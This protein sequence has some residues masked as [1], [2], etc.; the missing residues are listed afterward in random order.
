MAQEEVIIKFNEVSFSYGRHI[1]VLNEVSFSVREN[2]KITLMGQNGAGKSTI[3]GLITKTLE[4]DSGA[5]NIANDITIATAKQVIPISHMKLTIREFFEQC[6]S[7]KVYDID[8]K[9]DKALEVVN[10]HIASHEH[11]IQSFS[12]GQRARLLLASAIIQNPDILLLDEPTNNLD[13]A[14][15]LHLT[16]FLKEYNKTCIVIS[17]DAEF[18]NSFTQG[19]LYLDAFTHKIEQYIGD[20]SNVVEQISVRI[21]K[22]NRKNAQLAKAIIE[23][24]ERANFFAN[25]GGKMRLVAKKMREKAEEAEENKVSV[26]KEDKAIRA[27]IIP[28][29]QSL[30]GEILH[31]S[32]LTIIKNHKPHEKKVEISLR[33]NNHLL[34][35]GPNGIGKSTLLESLAKGSSKGATIASGITVGYYQQDFALRQAQGSVTLINTEDTVYHALEKGI[36][37]LTEDRLRSVSS[38]FLI[39]H[40]LMEKKI[41]SLSEGQKGLVMLARLVLQKPGLLILDEPTNHMNFRHLPIIASALNAYEGAMILV[42]HIPEFVQQIRIDEILDLEK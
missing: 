25:K 28:S 9:I 14:G 3:F 17:H 11:M 34:L 36:D 32:S 26:R 30:G 41:G 23:N 27:F 21:E 40:D 15:I 22:E 20:Y 12:G 18:L 19:V 4:P 1:P 24:K 10:L 31:I 37:D 7:Q 29:Q 33:K 6:F 38:G 35:K 42:S 8:P 5:I 39:T 13:P 2:S 16:N